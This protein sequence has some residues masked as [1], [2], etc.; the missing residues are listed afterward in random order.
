MFEDT[1]ILVVLDPSGNRLFYDENRKWTTTGY[2]RYF[3]SFKAAEIAR[4][5]LMFPS[6]VMIER[7][8]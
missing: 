5:K 6:M 3:S 7:I 4:D 8:A 1:W 2:P